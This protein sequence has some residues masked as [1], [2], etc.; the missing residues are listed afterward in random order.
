MMDVD[1]IIN[2]RRYVCRGAG[3]IT[4]DPGSSVRGLKEGYS[5]REAEF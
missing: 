2:V 1:K 3:H 4:E 5:Q